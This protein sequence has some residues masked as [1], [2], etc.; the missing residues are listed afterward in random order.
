[1]YSSEKCKSEKLWCSISYLSEWSKLKYDDCICWREMWG[2][3]KCSS[4]AAGG[5]ILYNNLPQELVISLLRIYAKDSQ[6]YY[7]DICSTMSPFPSYLPCSTWFLLLP[8]S[9]V[10]NTSTKSILFPLLRKIFWPTIDSS[11]WPKFSWSRDY[12]FFNHWYFIM[13]TY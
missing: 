8:W 4:I 13:S 9:S 12:Q 2:K 3:G 6:S 10:P 5:A 7:K 1:M 11:H